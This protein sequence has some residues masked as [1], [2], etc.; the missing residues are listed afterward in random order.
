M[1]TVFNCAEMWEYI[2]LG[3]NPVRRG[4]VRVKG[5]TKRMKPPRILTVEEFWKLVVKL[6]EPYRTMV[7][8]AGS[9]GLRVSEIVALQWGDFNFGKRIV[10]VQRACVDSRVDDVKSEY[11]GDELPLNTELIAVLLQ[12]KEQCSYIG[13]ADWVF[14]SP[15]TGKPFHACSIQQDH[16]RPA[17]EGL[18]LVDVGWH[19]M[20]HSYRSWL[21]A[22]GAPI[23]VQQKLMRHAQVSTTMNVYGNAL[24]ESKRDANSNVVEM[25]FRSPGAEKAPLAQTAQ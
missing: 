24:M 22:T 12:W 4:L 20:R 21:D 19:T 23:G 17:A 18:G 3:K 6:K 1:H 14:R 2:D 25:L 8:V 9:L 16:I 11:S 7:I 10:L 13:A 5:A 15:K